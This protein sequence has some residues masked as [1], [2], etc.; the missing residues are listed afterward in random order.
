MAQRFK[1]PITVEGAA[2]AS[3]QAVAAKVDGDTQ[4][5]VQIDAGG[6]ITWGDGSSA[7]DANL[8]RS[9]A[10]A[11]KTD[12]TLEAASGLITLTTSG[13]PTASLSDGALAI[14]TTND[15]F[16]IR[17]GG[18]WVKQGGGGAT[19]SDAAPSNPVAG[20]LW[21]ETDTGAMYIYYDSAWIEVGTAGVIAMS[22]T[23]TPP[24][25][26]GNGDLWFDIDTARTYVYYDDSSSQQW[27]EV[28]AAS[29][30][31]NGADGSIQ[32]AT[33]GTF[34]SATGLIW[35]DANT[36]LEV[37][38]V[39]S[40]TGGLVTLTSAG[41]PTATLADGAIAVDTTND[42]FYYRSNS[43]WNEV[44]GTTITS[45]STDAVLITMEIG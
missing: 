43:T 40:A 7:G 11:L 44:S 22:T 23:S 38:G 5:R 13:A 42:T 3:S 6:K 35:D 9:A 30:A 37:T 32:F 29:A 15:E 4:N 45:S 16:Y 28:G 36:E 14:D 12:D 41:A 8:Y 19:Q 21:Y 20:D 25:S 2:A 1:T 27:I 10:N 18:A 34:D 17:S 39:I 31:A 24:S 26:P 33:G